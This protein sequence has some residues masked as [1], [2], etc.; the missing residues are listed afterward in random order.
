MF[1]EFDDLD[2]PPTNL[3]TNVLEHLATPPS[4][5]RS[6]LCIRRDVKSIGVQT[7]IYEVLQPPVRKFKVC[8]EKDK[9]I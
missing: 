5:S 1:G 2:E 7:D 4:K 3:D 8:S 6:G 9:V